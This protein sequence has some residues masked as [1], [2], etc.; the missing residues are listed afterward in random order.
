MLYPIY[1]LLFGKYDNLYSGPSLELTED[2]VA[3]SYKTYKSND[4]NDMQA[5]IDDKLTPGITT[6]KLILCLILHIIFS[7]QRSTWYRTRRQSSGCR[8][9]RNGS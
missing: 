7:C 8:L 3:V 1:Q 6:R 2:Q 5:I 9:T 4:E